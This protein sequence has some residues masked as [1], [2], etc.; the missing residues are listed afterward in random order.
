MK[1]GIPLSRLDYDFYYR[2]QKV[3]NFLPSISCS[4][5]LHHLENY[6]ADLTNRYGF[7]TV[8]EAIIRLKRHVQL[9]QLDTHSIQQF[10]QRIARL[11]FLCPDYVVDEKL[12]KNFNEKIHVMSAQ[13]LLD[14]T[15][16]VPEQSR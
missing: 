16:M 7:I 11:E 5:K 9:A 4:L 6:Q 1:G 10:E 2:L 3:A 8:R 15:R 13:D 14:K 12:I